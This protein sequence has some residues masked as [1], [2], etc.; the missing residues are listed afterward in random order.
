MR[1]LLSAQECRSS[2][3]RISPMH[4]IRIKYALL[5]ICSVIVAL[6]I[7]TFIGVQS[8]RKLGNDD[9][10]QMLSLMCKTGAMNLESYFTSVERS[11][12]TVASLVQN[13]L[14]CFKYS[15]ILS[16]FFCLYC[17]KYSLILSLYCLL[18][19]LL[20]SLILS[21]FF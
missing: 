11:A 14:D 20:Y 17:L 3:A 10:D 19:S 2:D 4:S 16:L 13:S 8:I 18:Y 9:A 6:G 12:Q 21:L 5:T 7:A 1:Y 15:L